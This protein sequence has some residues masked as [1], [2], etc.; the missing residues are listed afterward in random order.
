MALSAATLPKA[1]ERDGWCSS[2]W[3]W[4]KTRLPLK[5]FIGIIL[6]YICIYIYIYIYREYIG[7][8]VSQ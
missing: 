7:L 8:M 1:A 3:K 2:A 5:G 4:Y 6:G